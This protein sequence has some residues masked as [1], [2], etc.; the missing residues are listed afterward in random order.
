[1]SAAA[2]AAAVIAEEYGDFDLDEDGLGDRRRS[3]LNAAR[4]KEVLAERRR[5]LVETRHREPGE[6]PCMWVNCGRVLPSL[7]SLVDHLHDDHL[8]AGPKT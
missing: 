7:E 4:S 2:V 3:G 8:P 6:R 5:Q 1:M